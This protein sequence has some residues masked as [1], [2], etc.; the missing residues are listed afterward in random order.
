MTLCSLIFDFLTIWQE[1]IG[2]AACV[3]DGLLAIYCDPLDG[4]VGEYALFLSRGEDGLDGA[5]WEDNFFAA[6]LVML[7]DLVV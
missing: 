4:A 5:V 7:L 6:I 3:P 1:D 2:L